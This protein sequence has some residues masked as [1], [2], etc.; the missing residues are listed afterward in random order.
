PSH[1]A[2]DRSDSATDQL[3]PNPPYGRH[4]GILPGPEIAGAAAQN[5]IAVASH[6]SRLHHSFI[7]IPHLENLAQDRRLYKPVKILR[8]LLSDF[9]KLV[10]YTSKTYPCFKL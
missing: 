9:P 4:V 2:Y 1:C 6:S 10:V 7:F 8:L 3:F 5:W